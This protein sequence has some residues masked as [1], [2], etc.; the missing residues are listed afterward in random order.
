MRHMAPG[1]NLR[2][3]T[4]IL[5]KNIFKG[6]I[7]WN[8]AL[9]QNGGPNVFNGQNTVNRGLLTIRSDQMDSVT[10][11]M[12]FYSLG[13][14]SK[15]V[16]PNAVR[17]NTNTFNNDMENVAFLNPDKSIVLCVSSQT[18]TSRTVRVQWRN[19]WFE[20]VVP[21]QGAATFKFPSV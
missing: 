20:A 2:Y 4:V 21:G 16:D 12:G 7:M 18:S 17:I 14:F 1:Y 8:V 15:F 9:D 5:Y 3:S 11:E 6:V 10:Y 19:K 13:H